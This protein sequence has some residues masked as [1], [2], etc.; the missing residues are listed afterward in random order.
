MAVDKHCCDGEHCACQMTNDMNMY[1]AQNL[2]EE[3]TTAIFD[4]LTPI[5][6]Q[7]SKDLEVIAKEC[8]T[9]YND[10]K[11][12]E[13]KAKIA[14]IFKYIQGNEIYKYIFLTSPFMDIQGYFDDLSD[15][16][17]SA[18]MSIQEVE[19]S[20][21][22][23]MEELKEK[24]ESTSKSQIKSK[25]EASLKALPEIKTK[26]LNYLEHC[27]K[28]TEA[29][30]S[31]KK[32]DIDFIDDYMNWFM[33]TLPFTGEFA[34][35]KDKFATLYKSF[36]SIVLK[37]KETAEQLFQQMLQEE[38]EEKNEEEEED[39][40]ILDATVPNYV[41]YIM[42]L[43]EVDPEDEDDYIDLKSTIDGKA[44]ASDV[45]DYYTKN[46]PVKKA[47]NI[48]DLS[49]VEYVCFHYFQTIESLSLLYTFV[50]DRF[51]NVKDT[52]IES[53]D[54]VSLNN[55]VTPLEEFLEDFKAM[56]DEFDLD[57]FGDDD[58]DEDD[59]DDYDDDE[60]DG[61]DEED[62][63]GEDNEIT[64]EEANYQFTY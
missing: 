6:N 20:I 14:D 21:E 36:F 39:D 2:F 42:E 9:L 48:K 41:N 1:D 49:F 55:E 30:T 58:F 46:C 60:E 16:Q 26:L 52:M 13:A 5:F 15:C 31:S 61:E 38:E 53:D 10:K 7:T 24:L 54:M 45:L 4:V 63:D 64:E 25:L 8:F 62:G 40:D 32:V 19:D 28:E 43:F 59:Y 47:E 51:D 37:D 50:L 29:N 44:Y 3:D 35:I 17:L 57:A 23:K 18:D 56:K 33:S 27:K 22:D 34:A 11:S 12:E